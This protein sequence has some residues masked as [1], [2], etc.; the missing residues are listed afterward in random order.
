MSNAA[1]LTIKDRL[2]IDDVVAAYA[3]GLDADDIDAVLQL[4]VPD[5]VF[6]TYG[7][8]FVG[9]DRIRRMMTSAP[10]GLHL[11]GRSLISPHPHGAQVKLQLMF[12]D[13]ATLEQRLALYDETLTRVADEWKFE[14]IRVQFL[15]REG[16][17]SDRPG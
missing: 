9:H 14:R 13:A 3:L 8:E 12:V 1:A 11:A 7:R 4:F 15:T 10:K 16:E 2:A 5:G 6:E 17:L